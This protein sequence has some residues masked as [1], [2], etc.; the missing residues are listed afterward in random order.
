MKRVLFFLAVSLVFLISCDDTTGN[1]G[2]SLI[3]ENDK[4]EVYADS[5]DVSSESVLAGN[6]AAYSAT[7]YL[8]RMIDNESKV[9]VTA[10]FMTQFHVLDNYEMPVKDSI[11]SL[12]KDSRVI[13]DSC[14]IRLFYKKIYGDKLSQ[15]KLTVYELDKPIEEGIDYNTDFDPIAKGYIRKGGL[16]V[17]RSYT[18]ADL[19]EPDSVRNSSKYE[20]NINI[21]LHDKY[22]DKD[23]KTYN[24]FGTYLMR[25]YQEKPESFRNSYRFLHDVCAGFYFK[26]TDGEGS[27]ANI[28]QAQINIYYRKKEGKKEKVTFT[29]LVGTEEVLQLTNFDD[30]KEQL[31]SLMGE[32]GHTYLSSPAGIF[33]QITLPDDI[34]NGKYQDY[35]I[36][37]AKIEVRCVNNKNSSVYNFGAPQHIL[38]LPADSV[39][40]FFTHT[41]L[42]DNK[43]S[44]LATYN[45]VRNSYIFNNI[46]GIINLFKQARSS[47]VT[48][49]LGKVLLIPVDLQTITTGSGAEKKTT[50]TMISNKMGLSSTK[51]LGNTTKGNGLRITVVYSKFKD[52]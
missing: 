31:K 40:A 39:K 34:V 15:M 22:T 51:L 46:S 32:T 42:N 1:L 8:G 6:I 21:R 3:P 4:L 28:E 2:V 36:N 35:V 12:D 50:V 25:K 5:F 10:N 45:P 29:K 13:A 17:N 44:F 19:T 33:T 52:K 37:S 48:G 38:M 18:L 20:K 23:G 14:E 43:T 27:M 24:N 30:N 47:S 11:A 49:N 26:I 7:G 16:R 41:R 9:N